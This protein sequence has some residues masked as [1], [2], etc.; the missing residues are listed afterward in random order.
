MV[1]AANVTKTGLLE[2]GKCWTE[3]VMVQNVNMHCDIE[4]DIKMST[5]VNKCYS[6]I[7]HDT[8]M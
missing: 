6:M 8:I 2:Y 5:N 3:L 4:C 7:V 1:A